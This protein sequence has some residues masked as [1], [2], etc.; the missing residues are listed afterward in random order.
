MLLACAV[1]ET[2]MSMFGYVMCAV[3]PQQLQLVK[4]RAQIVDGLFCISLCY[5][6]RI[7]VKFRLLHDGACFVKIPKSKIGAECSKVEERAGCIQNGCL[8]KY[9]RRRS[10]ICGDNI[11]TDRR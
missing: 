9:P 11:K 8:R 2:A 6:W 5:E 3:Q 7:I 4:V 1:A 10:N